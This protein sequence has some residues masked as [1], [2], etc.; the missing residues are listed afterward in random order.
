MRYLQA[1]QDR[2]L[3]LQESVGSFPLLACQVSWVIGERWAWYLE[4][5]SGTTMGRIGTALSAPGKG[6]EATT[7]VRSRF[8]DLARK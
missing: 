1:Q 6:G 3:G 5:T 8:E 7:H 4:D 2:I